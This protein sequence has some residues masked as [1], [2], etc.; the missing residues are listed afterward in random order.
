M[1]G[2]EPS[3]SAGVVVLIGCCAGGLVGSLFARSSLSFVVFA[4]AGVAFGTSLG[5]V[6][7]AAIDRATTE[8][9]D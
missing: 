7:L 2:I 6:A 1:T 4:S 9:R 8:S 5:I 3:D